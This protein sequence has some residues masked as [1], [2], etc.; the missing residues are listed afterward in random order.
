MEF[1]II[2]TS[3]LA[4]YATAELGAIAASSMVRRR[5]IVKASR[6]VL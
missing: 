3:F 6:G 5:R 2:L 1:V 4:G